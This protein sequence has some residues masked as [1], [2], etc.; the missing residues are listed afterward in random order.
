MAIKYK[1]VQRPNPLKKEANKF[2]P[3]AISN[4]KVELKE[5]AKQKYHC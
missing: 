2:Y 5:I 1:A 3:T 4:G